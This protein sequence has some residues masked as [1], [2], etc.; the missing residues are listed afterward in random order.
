[1]KNFNKV[2]IEKIKLVSNVQEVTNV[3]RESRD[4]LSLK[5]EDILKNSP[6]VQSLYFR[7]PKVIPYGPIPRK[8]KIK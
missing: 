7:I 1:M 3:F 6:E 2:K 8:G 5:R 4:F